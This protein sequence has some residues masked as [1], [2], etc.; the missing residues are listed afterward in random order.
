MSNIFGNEV[1]VSMFLPASHFSLMLDY[2]NTVI[3]FSLPIYFDAFL[4]IMT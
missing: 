2:P 3:I 4:F 1:T